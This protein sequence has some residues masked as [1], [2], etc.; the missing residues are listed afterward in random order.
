MDFHVTSSSEYGRFEQIISQFLLKTLHVVLESRIP[1]LKHL[2]RSGDP[3]TDSRAKKI[4]KWFN[5]ALG[6]RPAALEKLQYW[7]K[8]LMD[9]MI[10]DIIFVRRELKDSSGQDFYLEDV[11]EEASVETV[12]ERWVVQYENHKT[13]PAR[14]GDIS[15]L[16]KKMYQK[17]IILF[18][19]LCSMMRHLPAYRVFKQL[20]T[21]FQPCDIDVVYKVSSFSDPFSREDEKSMKQYSFNPVDGVNGKLCVSVTYRPN[22]SEFN[23]ENSTACPPVIIADYVGSP[24]TDPMRAFPSM[25]KASRTASFSLRGSRNL[26]P[27]PNQRP[28]S[29]SSGIHETLAHIQN[30]PSSGYSP[31]HHGSFS[32]NDVS[33]APAYI[34]GQRFQNYKM[35]HG[36]HKNSCF[37][38]SLSP[39]FS[40]SSSPSTAAYQFS[41]NQSRLRPESAPVAIPHPINRSPNYLSPN[42]SDPNRN[43]LPPFSPRHTRPEPSPHGSPCPSGNRVS[44]KLD[45]SR[46][47]DLYTAMANQSFGS[48]VSRDSRDESGRFSGLH[49]D[50]S[51]PRKEFSRNSSRLSFQD[52]LDDCDF[53]CPFDVDD[54]ETSESQTSQSFSGRKGQEY[55]ST[56]FLGR[57]SQEAAVGA[58][59]HMLR[60]APPLRQDSSFYSS[61]SH[62]TQQESN[63]GTN[64]GCFIPRRASDALE[65]LKSY[66][67]MKDILLSK[68]GNHEFSREDT[69]ALPLDIKGRKI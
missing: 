43:S 67:D 15:S 35:S 8:N 1:S 63:F 11:F 60:T 46:N 30:H 36:H 58:L 3:L 49:S 37:E 31:V 6:D 62:S 7:H 48:K 40:P 55:N 66:R 17:S 20:S 47:I 28:H 41:P 25:D 12:V 19:C 13:M 22:L 4:D 2:D 24:A 39:P 9:P 10:I 52:D 53:S 33:S 51:S 29:W 34:H 59:V 61:H 16:Y 23:L 18:R 38:E 14:P 57:K 56:R 54:V 65:E 64:S 21:S 27:V 26:P 44:K 50:G 5:L 69:K 42:Q 45:T 68:S 32:P